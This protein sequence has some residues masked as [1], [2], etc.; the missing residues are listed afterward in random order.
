M[1]DS[2]TV[3]ASYR[4]FAATLT[5]DGM[6]SDPWVEGAPRFRMMPVVLSRREL[7]QLYRA[8]EAI[9]ALHDEVA[10]LC[11]RHPALVHE[12]FDWPD[13]HWQMWV[14]S[15]GQWHGVARADVFVTQGGPVVCELNSDTP[16][17][18]AEAVALGRLFAPERL[19]GQWLDPNTRLIAGLRDLVGRAADGVVGELA[20]TAGPG[21]VV[22]PTVGILYP[23]ELT[24][25]LCVIE[26]LVRC[27][28]ASGFRVVLGSP[29]NLR[30]DGAGGAMLF[31]C[32]CPVIY[33]HYKTDWW[34]ERRGVWRDGCSIADAAPLAGPLS[35]LLS[36]AA[37]R[38]CAVINPWGAVLTQNKRSMALMWEA[39]ELLSPR[40]QAAI[41]RYVP[42][43]LRLE[44]IARAT[45]KREREAWV[46]KTDYGAEGEEV[47]LGR[48]ATQSDWDDVVDRALP[49]RWV[50]QRYFQC[51]RE[52]DG[53]MANYGVYVVR[54]TAC[55]LFTRVQSGSTDRHA[56]S[57]ATLVRLS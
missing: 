37:R 36:A 45:L 50:A 53:T 17:G 38:R 29:F 20:S 31:G 26:Q 56:L 33:R 30:P 32:A 13:T 11:W 28:E 2:S 16:S 6:L 49:R 1:G 15:A 39:L 34:G 22:E 44:S 5:E 41:R 40:G 35:R 46:L 52:P 55:G 24:D 51:Q 21:G 42:L 43:T 10:R 18:Q 3:L 47:V 14:A 54:G 27:F 19:A 57:A 7:S 8:G 9:V 23:T 4:D 12:F 25:E 48:E